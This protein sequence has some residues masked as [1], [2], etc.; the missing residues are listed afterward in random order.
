[1]EVVKR[2]VV[3]RDCGEEGE[4]KGWCILDFEGS[5]TTLYNN[6]GLLVVSNVPP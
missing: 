6:T 5:G 1:M 2:S 3:A 4:G